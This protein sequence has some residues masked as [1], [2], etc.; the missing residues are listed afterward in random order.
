MPLPPFSVSAFQRFP[1]AAPFCFPDFYFSCA[2]FR[3]FRGRDP[4]PSTINSQ[5]TE[6]FNPRSPN[7]ALQAVW[8]EVMAC[9][10][11][12]QVLPKNKLIVIEIH[13]EDWAVIQAG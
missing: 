7:S 11:I 5:P 2:P 13:D 8:W 3:V 12:L 10:K 1:L 4:Q 6:P 9:G